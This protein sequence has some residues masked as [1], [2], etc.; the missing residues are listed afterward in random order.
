M[1]QAI[2][3]RGLYLTVLPMNLMCQANEVA[4]SLFVHYSLVRSRFPLLKNGQ[5]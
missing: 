5:I 1:V 2:L 3:F 4:E